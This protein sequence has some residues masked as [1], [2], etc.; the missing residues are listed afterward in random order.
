MTRERPGEGRAMGEG[1][2]GYIKEGPRLGQVGGS[3]CIL[4]TVHTYRATCTWGGGG[5]ASRHTASRVAD[6]ASSSKT[7]KRPF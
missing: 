3:T 5:A 4:C 7:L 2:G 1:G 6:S